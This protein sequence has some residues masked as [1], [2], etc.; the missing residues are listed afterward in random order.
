MYMEKIYIASVLRKRVVSLKL[1]GS[2][3]KGCVRSTLSSVGL[4]RK[5][6]KLQTT[7]MKMLRMVC[8][9]P[10]RDGISNE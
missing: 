1:R 10:L 6:R 2:L 8:G 9:K 5:K 3:Y 4:K 7:E